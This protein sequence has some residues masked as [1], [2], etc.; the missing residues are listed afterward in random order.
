MIKKPPV[1]S[2]SEIATGNIWVY[3]F[4]RVCVGVYV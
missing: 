4:Q 2:S 1:V 3:K